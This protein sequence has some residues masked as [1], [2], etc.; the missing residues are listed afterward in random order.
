MVICLTDANDLRRQKAA[1]TEEYERKM[2]AFE[3][4]DGTEVK[5]PCRTNFPQQQ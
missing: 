1:F 3:E 5:K 4:G 2:T